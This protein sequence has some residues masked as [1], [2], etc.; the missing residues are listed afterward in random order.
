MSLL[1][2]I[3][4]FFK[5]GKVK[6]IEAPKEQEYTEDTNMREDLR[7][8]ESELEAAK[9]KQMKEI[10]REFQLMFAVKNVCGKG[11]NL[12]DEDLQYVLQ[13]KL[14]EYGYENELNLD[15]LD[16]AILSRINMNLNTEPSRVLS[17]YINNS[18]EP[19]KNIAVLI[20]NVRTNAINEAKSYGDEQMA[21]GYLPTNVVSKFET[22]IEEQNRQNE[23]L[24]K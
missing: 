3:K 20:N 1:D 9:E 7:V 17:E 22:M 24:A 19:S 15:K 16:M 21:T 14:K 23:E 6:Q 4:A 13:N 18:Q 10:K 12:Y 5:I 2:R 8:S 11:N